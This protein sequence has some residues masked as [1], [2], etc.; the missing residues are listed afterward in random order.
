LVFASTNFDTLSDCVTQASW[1][2]VA[3]PAS[4]ANNIKFCKN[5]PKS[6][7]CGGPILLSK[8]RKRAAGASKNVK[9]R[10]SYP[11]CAALSSRDRVPLRELDKHHKRGDPASAD[12]SK[13]VKTVA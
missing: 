6:A 12:L 3:S 1:A 8:K 7:H 9:F 4:L 2:H 5:I 13:N 10:I 11:K